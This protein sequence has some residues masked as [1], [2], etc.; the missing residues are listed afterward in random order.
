MDQSILGGGLPDAVQSSQAPLEFENSTLD[1]GSMRKLGP[2]RCASK[3]CPPADVTTAAA[4]ANEEKISLHCGYTR[5]K[6]FLT[7]DILS[8]ILIKVNL[9]SI[10]FPFL[11]IF[12]ERFPKILSIDDNRI[13]EIRDWFYN[14]VILIILL[15][16]T[17]L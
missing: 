2:R 12:F 17:L 8:T 6:I 10:F 16:S 14:N 4:P 13:F 9:V 7:F 15:G 5:G 3:P 11:F 1:G